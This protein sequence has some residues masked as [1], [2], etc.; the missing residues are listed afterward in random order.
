MNQLK[1]FP[2]PNCN[3]ELNYDADKS[4]LSCLHCNSQFPI[5]IEK[6][7]LKEIDI[8]SFKTLMFQ[9][10]KDSYQLDYNCSKCGKINT[11]SSTLSFFE[12]ENC[13]NNVINSSAY[14]EKKV[15][16]QGII[17]FTISKEKAISVFNDWIGKGFWNDSDLK[18][19][20]LIDNLK[21]IYLPF[22]TFDCSTFN[23]WSGQSGTHYY[24][25]EY[26]TDDKGE[27]QSNRIQKTSWS[28]KQ[29]EF[30]HLTNDVLITD[31]DEIPQNII[32]E[33]Y[34]FHLDELLPMDECF[35]LGWNAKTYQSKMEECYS[36]YKDK[37]KE[38]VTSMS[39]DYLKDDTYSNLQV[40]TTFSNETYKYII[41][42]IWYCSYLFK[43][44][45]YFFI[46]NGQTAKVHGNKPLS[47]SKIALAIVLVVLCIAILLFLNG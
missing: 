22:W 3:S 34:P 25:N 47:T 39:I 35:L 12:C 6:T 4:K 18:K 42:P 9:E 43:G 5:N 37:V 36:M 40:S 14:Q 41:L 16:P 1:E 24:E 32:D 15:T 44:K 11:V 29:G 26:Y 8:N 30:T 45:S 38:V 19:M 27:Q 17:P 7:V 28:F 21:G 20:S 13:G 33:I 10:E 2:C 23:Q 31:N 46:I